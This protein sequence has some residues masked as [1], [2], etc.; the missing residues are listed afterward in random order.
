MSSVPQMSAHDDFAPIVL[1]RY[2]LEGELGRGTMGVV[3]KARDKIIGRTVALKT[4][5]LEQRGAERTRL[6]ERLKQEARSAGSLDHPNLI[7]IFDADE[8]GDQFYLSMQFVEGQTL[9]CLL[10]SGKPL[11]LMTVFSYVYQI[12]DAVGFAHKHGIIHRDLK[13]ANMMVTHQGAIK[14]LDF[15]LAKLEDTGL[16]QSGMLIGTPRYMSPEQAAGRRVDHR[17]DIFSLGAV[18]YELFSGEKAFDGPSFTSVL[19]KVMNED[20]LPISNIHPALPRGIE[21]ILQKALAKDPADRFQSCEE[22]QQALRQ[23]QILIQTAAAPLESAGAPRSSSEDSQVAAGSRV[24]IA[25][26]DESRWTTGM[27][28]NKISFLV[29]TVG[30]LIVIVGSLVVYRSSRVTAEG[31]HSST[32]VQ[33]DSQANVQPQ[34]VSTEASKSDRKTTSP[35][36]QPFPALVDG[37][38]RTDVPNLLRKASVHFGRGEYTEARHAYRIVLRLDPGNSVALAGIHR[39]QAAVRDTKPK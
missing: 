3:Y 8:A 15:G 33:T 36:T 24:S 14:V 18:F 6:I 12:C 31:S 23:E 28:R 34:A 1:S 20:P 27:T 4:I 25:G 30:V 11:P 13:P 21:G 17:A 32:R 29:S 7:T 38:R 39:T 16:S 22:M 35:L 37:F 9:A 5:R 10:E 19:Y 26:Q 2:D